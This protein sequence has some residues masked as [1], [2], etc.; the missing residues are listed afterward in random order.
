MVKQKVNVNGLAIAPL[1]LFDLDTLFEFLEISNMNVNMLDKF[2]TR[3]HA[4]LKSREKH[5]RQTPV[6]D[7]FT[8]SH[9]CFEE[10]FASIMEK[11]LT[12]HP[13]PKRV[14][15]FLNSIGVTDETLESF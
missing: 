10:V 9:A 14:E 7:N 4:I 5:F 12:Y 8:R 11:E 13:I 3:Y 6:Q 2:I 1:T 15:I